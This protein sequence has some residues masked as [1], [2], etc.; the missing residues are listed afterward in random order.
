MMADNILTRLESLSLNDDVEKTAKLK[1]YH[2]RLCSSGDKF[3]CENGYIVIKDFEN[4]KFVALKRFEDKK[5]YLIILCM[6]CTD[7]RV[8]ESLSL[9][10]DLSYLKGH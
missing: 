8:F 2:S 7:P 3:L 10:E 9:N 1:V 4:K 5:S 6:N